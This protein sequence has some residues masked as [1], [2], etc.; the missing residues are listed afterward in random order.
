MI[1]R[2]RFALTLVKH[3]AVIGSE[4]VGATRRYEFTLREPIT[5]VDG[6]AKKRAFEMLRR[7]LPEENPMCWEATVLEAFA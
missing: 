2:S 3:E 7:D 1:S 6:E 4:P 5:N